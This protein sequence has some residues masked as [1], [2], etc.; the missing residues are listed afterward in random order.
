MDKTL[1][2]LKEFEEKKIYDLNRR[3]RA[4]WLEKGHEGTKE[5]FVASKECGFH[6]LITELENNQGRNIF[7]T[8]EIGE[9]CG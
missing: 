2:Q 1:D 9:W 8:I 5:F 7:L 4:K 6:S 3:S